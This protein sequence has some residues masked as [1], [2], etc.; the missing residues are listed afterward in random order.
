MTNLTNLMG[1]GVRR[2]AE[3]GDE[4]DQIASRPLAIEP[5]LYIQETAKLEQELVNLEESY[6]RKKAVIEQHPRMDHV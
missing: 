6:E 5:Q 3:R 1:R 2:K 4:L